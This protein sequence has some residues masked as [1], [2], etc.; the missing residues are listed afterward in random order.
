MHLYIHVPFCSRRC[1]YCDFA[2]AVRKTVPS[3]EFERAIRLEW[4]GWLS[5]PAWNES[6]GLETIYFGGG[7]PSHLD[8][9]VIAAL[10]DQFRRDRQ[11]ANDAEVTLEV[12]PEDVT[13]ERAS[14]WL[15]GGV[16]RFSVGAQSFSPAA[17]QWMHRTHSS[18]QIAG[19]LGTLRSAGAANISLDLI[20]GLPQ[21]I[22]RDWPA[23]LEEALGLEPD[24]LSLYALTV[25]P[26]TPLARWTARGETSL[27]PDERVAEEYLTAH[28]R[29]VAAGYE[30]YEVSNAARPGR[31]S[32]H[33]AAY[34]SRRPYLGLGPSAHSGFGAT[35]SWNVRE[36]EEYRRQLAG[37]SSVTAGSEQLDGDQIELEEIYLGL[38]SDHGCLASRVEPGRLEI[39]T[40]EGWAWLDGDRVRLTP[41][42]W[43]RLDALVA[44]LTRC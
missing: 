12:N 44:S 30:H 11:V 40:G 22:E 21:A 26:K 35:R 24:H 38:R 7:T 33:N 4:A 14:D 39:W 25:E 23:D 17:L 18:S 6:P 37:G 34:W 13:G 2:I 8:P 41:E 20:Y 3:D 32:R 29:L 28:A 9:S 5:H 36:W 10:L 1:S 31:R 15:R 27:S 19:A 16:N 42:G 43:L